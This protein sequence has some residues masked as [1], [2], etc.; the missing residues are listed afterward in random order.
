MTLIVQIVLGLSVLVGL[1]TIIMSS[2]NWH[3]TQLVLV[4]SIFFAA[5]GFLFLGAETVRMHQNLR[6]GIPKL[7]KNIADLE[8]KNDRLLNGSG[9]QLGILKLE[10]RLKIVTRE[11]GRVWRSVAPSGQ[12]DQQGRVSIEI[13]KPSP[14]GLE[15]DAIVYAFETGNASATDSADGKQYLGEFRVLEVQAGG[16]TLEPILLIDN[17]V[18]ERLA[19]SEGPWSLYETMP[20]DRHRLFAGLSIEALREML[21]D[22]SVEEYIR[23]GSEA[24]PD[25]DEWHVTG[26][27]ED[28]KRVGPDNIDQ[29]VKRLYDRSLRDYAFIFNEIAGEKVVALA[30][31]QAVTE[32]I[33]LLVKAHAGA[34]ETGKFRQQQIDTLG[35]DLAGMKQDRAAIESH[36]DAVLSLLGHFRERIKDYRQVN[37]GLARQFTESQ[38]G[39]VQYINSVSPAASR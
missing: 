10:H 34:E 28:G 7:E 38:L 5:I 18:G 19:A 29:A 13:A 3:W 26:L 37:S 30:K 22:E 32:D 33:A 11:R 31:Q 6:K 17:R 12:V 16:A 25:D 2:K 24:T 8:Q 23:H 9:E 20:I 39:M 35:N 15:K 4:L 27:D 1:V 21:P 36:R 14:H